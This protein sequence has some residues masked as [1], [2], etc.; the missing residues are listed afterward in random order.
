MILLGFLREFIFFSDQCCVIETLKEQIH[1]TT[2]GIFAASVGV[3]PRG[4]GAGAEDVVGGLPVQ[5]EHAR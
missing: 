4:A 3:L 2:S 1:I 5:R